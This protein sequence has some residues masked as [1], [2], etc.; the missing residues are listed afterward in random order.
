M[1]A[2]INKFRSPTGQLIEDEVKGDAGHPPALVWRRRLKLTGL[3]V[4]MISLCVFPFAQFF[5]PRSSTIV[6][7]VSAA[8]DLEPIQFDVSLAD[9]EERGIKN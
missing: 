7:D 5:I 6:P 8:E 2:D 9:V 1:K 4:L 3:I